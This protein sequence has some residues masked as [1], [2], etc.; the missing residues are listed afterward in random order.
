MTDQRKGGKS[1]FSHHLDQFLDHRALRIREMVVRGRGY[2]ASA[3]RGQVGVDHR[4]I[5]GKLRGKESPHQARAR[6]PMNRKDCRSLSTTA[7]KNLVA[8]D[9][10]LTGLE[11]HRGSRFSEGR[12]IALRV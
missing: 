12:G 5:R 7:I 9:V 3:V 11:S 1:E 4:V 2:T 10:D 8:G 6:K